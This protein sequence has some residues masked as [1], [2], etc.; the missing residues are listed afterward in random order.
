VKV[1]DFGLVKSFVAQ[2]ARL[3]V[4]EITQGGTFLGSPTY[5][6]PEQA[7][8]VAD[9]RS[10]I[11]SLGV[12]LY[13]ALVGR[14]PFVSQDTLELIFA[15]HKEAP[16]SF[17]AVRPDLVIPAALEAVVRR[18]LEKLPEQRYATMDEVLDA[19]RGAVGQPGSGPHLAPAPLAPATGPHASEGTMVLD[20]SVDEAAVAPRPAPRRAAPWVAVG[21]GALL[22][23]GAGVYLTRPGSG[24]SSGGSVAAGPGE[25]AS[26]PR[27]SASALGEAAS[28]PRGS[29]SASGSAAFAPGAAPVDAASV[30]G[31]APG[32]AASAPGAA[33]VDAASVDAA[34]APVRFRVSSEPVGARVF[35]KGQERGVTP[36][37]LEVPPGAEGVATA[38]LTFVLEGYATDRVMA[39]GKGEVHLTQRLQRQRS[40]GGRPAVAASGDSSLSAPEWLSAPTPLEAPVPVRPVAGTAGPAA[41]VG[42]VARPTGPIQLPEEATPPVE[43]G[44]NVPPE[45]PQ[46]AR[47][48]G[49]EGQ[50]ILKVVITEKGEVRDVSVLRGEEPFAS[51]AVDAVRTWRYRPALL[52]GRPIA[53]YRVLKVPFRLR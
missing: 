1:L 49:R 22:A 16:P 14:P 30:P 31:A 13:H 28:A 17:R 3:A 10:D 41:A 48:A 51:A 40:G 47:S 45:F 15:H 35:W 46:S 6:A 18:C 12:L 36:L 34:S 33:P 26:A 19:L 5:M 2:G 43:L 44:S 9:A 37:V 52:E 20:I 25:A 38:E 42:A 24:S 7:R 11:Y 21:L 32:S 53:V 50:V 39:G 8:N 4:P 29:A 27:G 23:L